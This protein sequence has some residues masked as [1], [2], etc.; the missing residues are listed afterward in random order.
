MENWSLAT[1]IIRRHV[2]KSV[3][4]PYLEAGFRITFIN[5]LNVLLSI[6]RGRP[7]TGIRLRPESPDSRFRTSH[8]CRVAGCT[9]K[10]LATVAIRSPESTALTALIRTSSVE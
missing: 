5:F 8:R 4:N 7:L 1:W 9:W 10:D 3:S 6:L 2:Q